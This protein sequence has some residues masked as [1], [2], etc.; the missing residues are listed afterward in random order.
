MALV[1]PRW[2]SALPQRWRTRMYRLAL[3]RGFL[4]AILQKYIVDPLVCS[5]RWIDGLDD[6]VVKLVNGKSDKS[7]GDD[8]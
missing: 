8:H 2:S 1:P 7:S 6:W 3:H 5:L 4:D